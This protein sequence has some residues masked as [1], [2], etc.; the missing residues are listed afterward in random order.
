[1]KLTILIALLTGV[2]VSAHFESLRGVHHEVARS[3]RA[4]ICDEDAD[5]NHGFCQGLTLTTNGECK[6]NKG[7]HGDFCDDEDC[8]GDCNHG[9]CHHDKCDC[10]A[11][12]EGD[13]CDA[14][15]KYE[16]KIVAAEIS[17]KTRAQSGC[18]DDIESLIDDL[19]DEDKDSKLDLPTVTEFVV[20]SQCGDGETVQDRSIIDRRHL[21]K[22][23]KDDDHT[24]PIV[25]GVIVVA[26]SSRSV[27]K[28]TCLDNLAT[29]ADE[30]S[31]HMKPKDLE[32]LDGTT[33]TM[34]SNDDCTVDTATRILEEKEDD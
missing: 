21:K 30:I 15:I 26:S 3:L 32:K 14:E 1:M 9:K 16:V 10:D 11:G 7:W 33:K 24:E 17:T 6:C 12:W 29:A 4:G 25:V 18:T 20:P 5:C 8:D 28:S 19:K 13:H 34:H 31:K 23:K 27:S 2:T 22:E